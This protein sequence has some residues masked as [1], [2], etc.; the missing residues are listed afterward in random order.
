MAKTEAIAGVD[1]VFFSLEKLNSNEVISPI[2]SQNTKKILP[3]DNS[4]NNKLKNRPLV[5]ISQD[6]VNFI[7]FNPEHHNT[8]D[9]IKAEMPNITDAFVGAAFLVRN[10]QPQP[11]EIFGE[12]FKFNEPR[13]RAFLG[14]SSQ[15]STYYWRVL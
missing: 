2:F 11:A 3:G 15:W 10:S 9:G 4:D 1:G 6:K 7:P 8:I 13:H 5:L 12:L 14:Y